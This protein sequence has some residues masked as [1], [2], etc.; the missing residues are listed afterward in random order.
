[1][2]MS[3][4]KVCTKDSCSFVWMVYDPKGL[5]GVSIT[6]PREDGVL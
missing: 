2:H 1:V 4:D 6:G 3:E 5:P